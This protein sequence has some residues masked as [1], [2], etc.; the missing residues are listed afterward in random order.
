MATI[1]GGY[2]MKARKI[3]DSKIATAPPHVREIWDWLI[4]EVNHKD[5]GRFKRGQTMRSLK[6][7]QE[8]LKWYV[9]Y[10][11]EMYSKSKCEMAMNWLRKEVMIETAK[12]TRGM[13]ITVL[14]YS[15]YQDSKNY[16]TNNEGNKKPTMNEQ[17][18]DTINKND[19]KDNK[20]KNREITMG[21]VSEMIKNYDKLK[22]DSEFEKVYFEWMEFRTSLKKPMKETT[23][24]KQLDFL[25]KQ[26]K[27][28][29]IINK[30]IMNGWQGL[31]ELKNNSKQQTTQRNNLQTFENPNPF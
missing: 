3:Q 16:E 17:T 10:R 11:K 1:E 15:T 19:K 26:D 24:K 21:V 28:I 4:K 25:E 23:I 18:H 2:Y 30:S 12:T 20:D 31:F 9:G 7:I 27:P 8:G 29:E 13:I 5:N 22:T 6:D 14:N